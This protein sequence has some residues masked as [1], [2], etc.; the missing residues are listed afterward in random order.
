MH[1]ELLVEEPSAE[2]AL[3]NLLAKILGSQVTYL[4][5]AYQG[6]QDLL[7]K[8]P[9]RL[10][11]YRHWLPA[12]WKIV[13]LIDED[14]QDC[15]QLK[16]AM[17][18]IAQQAGLATKTSPD[19]TGQFQVITRIAIEELEA[20]FFGDIA[21]LHQAYPRIPLTIAKQ[22]KYRQPD[23]ISGGTAEALE[24]LLV[25]YGY[26]SQTTG[27]LKIEVAR[28]I[29]PFMNPAQNQSPSFQQFHTALTNLL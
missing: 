27:M 9:A 24:K 5:H 25:R 28:N 4:I 13:V 20:W 8:L 23:E 11:G 6:K 3:D 2:V 26:Y 14:R 19:T 10:R 17:E 29:S 16:A 21:A 7:T 15:Q 1:I 12:D 18:Q 22:A